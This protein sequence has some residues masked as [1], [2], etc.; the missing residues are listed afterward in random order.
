MPEE[1]KRQAGFTGK[2]VGANAPP[3]EADPR[4]CAE[5]IKGVS[6]KILVPDN[7]H[8]FAGACDFEFVKALEPL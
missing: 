2:G 7:H 8:Y 3:P 6:P 1:N 5:R 4:V